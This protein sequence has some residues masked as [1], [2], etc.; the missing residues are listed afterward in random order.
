VQGVGKR[1]G[2]V[3]ALA[4]VEIQV[5]AGMV[6]GLVGA[7]GSGKTT[8]LHVAA[9]V[10]APDAGRVLVC[11]APAGTH[12]AARSTAFVPDEPA[13]LDELTV[14]ELVALVAA[15][16]GRVQG[17]GGR[18]EELLGRFGLDGLRDRRL[19]E[20]SRGQRRRVSTVAALQLTAPLVLVDEATAALDAR[21]V[22]ALALSLREAADAGAGVLVA[23]HDTGF[24]H[25]VADLVVELSL[26]SVRRPA[27]R[28]TR[29]PAVV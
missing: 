17:D 4:G 13:G 22:A 19:A 14:A 28:R 20:L 12:D 6:V 3:R 25:G 15:L 9:G 23:A 26:G 21:S 11:G 29:E 24:L 18:R 8:L 2:A 16:H 7:N 10:L 27:R 5:P 1:F